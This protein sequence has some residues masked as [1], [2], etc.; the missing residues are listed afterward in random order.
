MNKKLTTVIGAL[1]LMSLFM[2]GCSTSKETPKEKDNQSENKI[3]MQDSLSDVKNRLME[4]SIYD[5]MD[6]NKKSM[7]ESVEYAKGILP[8]GIK[9]INKTYK[10]ELGVT[11]V[12]YEVEDFE[13][14]VNYI[15]PLNKNRSETNEYD[16]E[17]TSGVIFTGINFKNK[18][19][20]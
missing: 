7:D 15:H 13:F 17:H 19:N 2:F 10:K 1:I 5:E 18:E 9:E 14:S 20:Y 8:N 11:I 3:S 6:P 12:T 16:L 4:A